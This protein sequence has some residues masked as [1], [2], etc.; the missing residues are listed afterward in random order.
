MSE[1]TRSIKLY[2]L[3][4]AGLPAWFFADPVDSNRATADEMTGPTGKKLTNRQNNLKALVM[5]MLTFAIQQAIY[6]GVLPEGIDTTVSL[7]VPDLMIKDLQK[8]A[9]TLAAVVNSVSVMEANGYIQSKTAARASHVVL[10]QIGVEVD[11]DEFD[12]AQAE[13]SQREANLVPEQTNLAKALEQVQG[14]GKPN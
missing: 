7:Q 8:A 10:S 14:T 12:K 1:A 13:K 3:G 4:G 5:Q 6:K 9:Q 11:P 2:G